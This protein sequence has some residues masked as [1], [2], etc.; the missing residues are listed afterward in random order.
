MNLLSRG[1]RETTLSAECEHHDPSYVIYVSGSEMELGTFRTEPSGGASGQASDIAI[2]AKE[3]LRIRRLLTDIYQKHCN[4]P[5]E[6]RGAGLQRFGVSPVIV[7][8]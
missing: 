1:K 6:S 2:H 8:N 7:C 3:I 4:K 5:G